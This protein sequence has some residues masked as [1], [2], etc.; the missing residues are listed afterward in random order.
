MDGE[1]RNLVA[2]VFDSAGP[3]SQHSTH[4]SH[5]RG[6]WQAR[7]EGVHG[8]PGEAVQDAVATL[9]RLEGAMA[10][11]PMDLCR[12]A[13]EMI[14]AEQLATAHQLALTDAVDES[15][16]RN[17]LDLVDALAKDHQTELADDM[18]QSLLPFCRDQGGI[19]LMKALSVNAMVRVQQSIPAEALEMLREYE[20]LISLP[21]AEAWEIYDT[22]YRNFGRIHYDLQDYAQAL[23]YFRRCVEIKKSKGCP[24]HWLDQWDIA[25]AS[26]HLAMTSSQR[27]DMQTSLELMLKAIRLHRDVE[28]DDS[29]ARIGML[30]GASECAA[31]A[32]DLALPDP[33]GEPAQLSE[34]QQLWGKSEACLREAHGIC[35]RE[36][37]AEE[38]VTL[39]MAEELAALLD[40]RG[41]SA[42]VAAE[43]WEETEVWEEIEVWE[44]LTE[45]VSEVICATPHVASLCAA[46]SEQAAGA[47]E[48]KNEEGE[49]L[50]LQVETEDMST[51]KQQCVW[52]C[53]TP[54]ASSTCD[55]LEAEDQLSQEQRH[56]SHATSQLQQGNTFVSWL[57]STPQQGTPQHDTPKPGSHT[58]SPCSTADGT[59][60]ASDNSKGDA[61]EESLARV[62]I[63]QAWDFPLSRDEKR[64][65]LAHL[66]DQERVAVTRE[67]RTL[68]RRLSASC[69][70]RRG[71]RSSTSSFSS[72]D[73][74]S[75]RCSVG[76][77]GG[78]TASQHLQG[79]HRRSRSPLQVPAS[80]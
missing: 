79:K 4:L 18:I 51:Q 31:T 27:L 65:R 72:R 58:E 78:P 3:V 74:G 8:M 11:L 7:V 47:D 49:H 41:V 13:S 5:H 9:S 70:G 1:L 16:L 69:D 28:R 25:N 36:F 42:S 55:A 45:R 66:F 38:P 14:S 63:R 32:A 67:C 60:P 76:S 59:S 44:D 43:V 17:A 50:Q 75:R 23:G 24:A 30:R 80:F 10:E 77:L 73:V 48:E 35:L 56:D 54:G 68:Q 15:L 34:R 53:L 12:A 46:S 33:R 22:L 52:H 20:S 21:M 57:E 29:V 37:G 2:D 64:L 71:R 62:P 61:L 39:S 40:R 6:Q 19:W 26:W